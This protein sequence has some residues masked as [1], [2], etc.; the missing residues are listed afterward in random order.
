MTN[1]RQDKLFDKKQ[2]KMHLEDLFFKNEVMK[3]EVKLKVFND[4]FFASHLKFRFL[5]DHGGSKY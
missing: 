5:Q 1:E 3:N 2:T 4:G